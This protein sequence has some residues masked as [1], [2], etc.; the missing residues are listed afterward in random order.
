MREAIVDR[1]EAQDR[2]LTERMQSHEAEALRHELQ[3][4]NDELQSLL[5]RM[6]SLALTRVRSICQLWG[7]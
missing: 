7:Q 4:T 3:S 5:S 6:H 2:E 1:M